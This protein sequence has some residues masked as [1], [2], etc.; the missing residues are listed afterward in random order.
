MVHPE[1]RESVRR[2]IEEAFQSGQDSG[3]EYRIIRP[4]G[5]TRWISA[6][7]RR[8]SGEFGVQDQLMGVSIDITERKQMEQE[9]HESHDRLARIVSSAMDAI[10]AIDDD[11]RVVVFNA[12]AEKM[13][14]CPAVDAIGSSISRFIPQR[15][16][17]EHREHIRRFDETGVTNRSMGTLGALWAMRANGEEFPIEA[18]ISQVHAAAKKLF[19]VIIRDIT[20]REQAMILGMKPPPLSPRCDACNI[21]KPRK[22]GEMS[23]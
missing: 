20:E 17:A 12:A 2:I 23:S 6:R 19:T 22:K 14:G 16:R 13:F 4:D 15:F 1:D 3:I 11:Q 21:P 10:I 9:L 7:G 8:R 5:E 18:S